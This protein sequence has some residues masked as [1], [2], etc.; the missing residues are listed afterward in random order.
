MFIYLPDLA[1]Y[2]LWV[3]AV[4]T[5]TKI[6]T[7]ETLLIFMTTLDPSY[8][9]TAPHPR[10]RCM[11]QDSTGSESSS[12]GLW[13][14]YQYTN[15]RLYT[16]SL[17]AAV[18]LQYFLYTVSDASS[19]TMICIER[20]EPPICNKSSHIINYSKFYSKYLWEH[21]DTLRAALNVLDILSCYSAGRWWPISIGFKPHGRRFS[22]SV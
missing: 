19:C 5:N 22:I 21:V 14:T 7:F 11:E 8:C 17:R 1:R 3:Q 12:T 13:S 16:P 6:E 15:H 2:R 9:D 20:M 4:R 10:H 18:F